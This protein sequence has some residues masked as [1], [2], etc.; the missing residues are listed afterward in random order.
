M[1]TYKEKKRAFRYWIVYWFIRSLIAM[2]NVAP[3]SVWLAFCG[4]LGNIAYAVATETKVLMIKHIGMAFPHLSEK[5]VKEFARKNFVM[6]AKNT[7]EI[8]RATRIKTLADLEKLIQ[9]H[10]YE[11]YERARDK[12]R[13][14][15]FLTCHV[16]AFDLQI[17]YMSLKGLRPLIIGTP[18]K[19][20]RLNDLLWQQ[21]NAH[22]A[23][24]VERGKETFRL[25]KELKSGGSLAILID[26][27][28]KVKSRFVNFFGMPAATPVGAA[29]FAVKTG[30]CIVP[31]YIH[32]GDDG[33]QH[34]EFLP[35]IE[36][37][38]TGDEENDLVVNTQRYSDF[39]EA[40]IRKHP[41]QW[42]WMHERWKTK[43]G[44]E[45]R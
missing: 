35:E 10:G 18:L 25:L 1:S 34:M 14:V 7:G 5:E 19:N 45:I 44:E 39:I 17:T 23:I 43:P 28:T 22:G 27:D 13:G 31:C 33:K 29:I 41:H 38:V 36:T 9:I 11:H 32:L 3:R 20:A 2:S 4:L 16:G 15:I 24:A 37:I 8:L 21:R 30:A 12:G 42:V 26:Q 40:Q 6:L